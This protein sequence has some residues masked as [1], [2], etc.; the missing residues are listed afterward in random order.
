[1]SKI[2]VGARA[3]NMDI[4]AEVAN[5]TRVNLVVDSEHMYTAGDDTGRTIEVECPWGTEKMAADI[6][7]RVGNVQYKPFSAEMAL[8]DPAFEI[9]DAVTI[10]GVYS[11]IADADCTYNGASLVTIK[12]PELDEIDDEYPGEKTKQSSIERKIAYTRSLISKT[13]EQIRQEVANEV[14]GLSASVTVELDSIRQE[15]ED[16]INGLSAAIEIDLTKISGRLEDA[17]SS[18]EVAITTL[19]GFTVTT[20]N[21][22]GSKTITL[23]DGVVTADAIAAGA[24]TANKIATGVIPTSTSDL[25]N[26]SGWEDYTGI[27]QI[28]GNTVDADY[29]QARGV[30]AR[31]L[32][33]GS[34]GLIPYS[35]ADEIGSITITETSTGYGL[36]ISTGEEAGGI[37]IEA[38]GGNVY[39]KSSGGQF[40]MLGDGICQL[41]GGPLV[42]DKNSF[43]TEL[44]AT[45]VYGQVFFLLK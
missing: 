16:E 20:T 35:G 45:G 4:G 36:G 18:I 26:D 40:L 6:L 39:A 25:T 31:Y 29:I 1:M 27:V 12:T 17:E 32:L 33:G 14:E 23:K 37:K 7:A 42:L 2:Y 13:A 22:D 10:G 34:V 21:E 15:V 44:P 8:L 5:I 28:I 24:I 43:G 30:T 41:N 3:Q 38:N 9:G 19:D 11:Q